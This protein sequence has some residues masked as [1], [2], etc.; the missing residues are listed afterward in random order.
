MSRPCRPS[1]PGD[2]ARIRH[3]LDATRRAMELA[4]DKDTS[5]LPPEDE[6]ALALVRL[7]EILGE[8][9]GRVTSTLRE[10]H[11]RVPWRDISAT[12][13]RIIHEYFNVDM[14]VVG[15]II[16]D[17]LPPLVSSLEVILDEMQHE[18]RH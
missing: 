2:E 7:L 12:R 15:A 1:K 6:T 16:R 5:N 4:K 3:M 11:P 10:K 9:A 14:E 18:T 17:D 13:N 8:A